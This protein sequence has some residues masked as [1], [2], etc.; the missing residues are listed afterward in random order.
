MMNWKNSPRP[1][2]I[3][4]FGDNMTKVEAIAYLRKRQLM[5]KLFS[6][7]EPNSDAAEELD[8]MEKSPEEEKKDLTAEEGGVL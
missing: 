1:C 6:S 7:I 5:D 2:K 3:D 4:S 8:N